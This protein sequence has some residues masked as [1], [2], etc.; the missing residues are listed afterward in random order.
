MKSLDRRGFLKLASTASVALMAAG[1]PVHALPQQENPSKPE[2]ILRGVN[3]G[4]WLV[5]ERWITPTLYSGVEAQ[6]EYT[7]CQKLGQKKAAQRLQKHRETWIT[8]DDFK[9]LAA[10]GINA[11]RLPVGYGVLEDNPPFI[12][13]ESTLDWIFRAAQAEGIRVVLDLHGVPGSQNGWDHSGRAGALEWHTSPE[14]IGHSLRIIE[15][16]AEFCRGRENLL[17][18]ELLNEPRK[19]VPMGILRSYYSEAYARVRK[20]LPPEKASVIF[21]DGFRG[22]AWGDFMQSPEYRGVLLDTHLYQCFSDEDKRRNLPSQVE[23]AMVKRKTELDSMRQHHRCIVGEWSCGL[24]KVALQGF[25]GVGLDNAMRAYGAAQLLSYETAE[26]WFFWTYRTEKD[27]GWSFR[28]CTERGW[29]P[30]RYLD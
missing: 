27:G 20:H 29:L 3:L 17:G 7:L 5:L 26:G 11:V 6:D 21:H 30:E 13:A 15:R 23:L 25:S 24:P 19:D 4:G 10:R 28:S 22:T 9:W 1:A 8:E 16:L 12:T 14:N 2:K 18:I